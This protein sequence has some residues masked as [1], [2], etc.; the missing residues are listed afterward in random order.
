MDIKLTYFMLITMRHIFQYI[1]YH[2]TK[3][4]TLDLPHSYTHKWALRS[5]VVDCSCSIVRIWCGC[6]MLQRTGRQTSTIALHKDMYLS[7]HYL[8]VHGILLCF[9]HTVQQNNQKWANLSIV[10]SVVL[11]LFCY[12]T[13]LHYVT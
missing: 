13:L 11:V 1:L 3:Y 8:Y 7:A 10:H 4:P 6:T 12:N 9:I 5:P 2:K